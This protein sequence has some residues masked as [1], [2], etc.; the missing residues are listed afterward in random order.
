[1]FLARKF[2]VAKMKLRRYT[3][4]KLMTDM[5]IL[6]RPDLYKGTCLNQCFYRNFWLLFFKAKWCSQIP[7]NAKKIS[8]S[9]RDVTCWDGKVKD[10]MNSVSLIIP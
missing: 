8:V 3:R 5:L 1:M 4:K 7:N 2:S 9:E 6:P 10:V